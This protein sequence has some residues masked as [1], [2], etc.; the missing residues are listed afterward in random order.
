MIYID[1]RVEKKF[2]ILEKFGNRVAREG[3]IRLKMM[4]DRN[5]KKE[6]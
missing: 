1:K 5:Y 6:N 3:R 4:I 2:R